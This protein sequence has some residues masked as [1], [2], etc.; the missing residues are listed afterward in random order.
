MTILRQVTHGSMLALSMNEQ[1]DSFIHAILKKCCETKKYCIKSYMKCEMSDISNNLL[2]LNLLSKTFL[3]TSQQFVCV[4]SEI[5][6]FILN[7]YKREWVTRWI[8]I[9]LICMDRSRHK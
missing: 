3:C 2:F 9:F 1:N 6:L 5:R 7:N 8:E 4:D